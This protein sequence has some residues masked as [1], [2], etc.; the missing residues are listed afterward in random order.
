[1]VTLKA[2]PARLR[3]DQSSAPTNGLMLSVE[4]FK[5]R[6]MDTVPSRILFERSTTR[7]HG[8]RTWSLAVPVFSAAI[9]GCYVW[10]DRPVAFWLHAHEF[11]GR[12]LE[13][14]GFVAR[15]PNPLILAGVVAFLAMA[16]RATRKP[17]LAGWE[18]VTLT[19]A[20]SVLVGEVIKDVLKWAFGRPSPE[21]WSASN[22]SQIGE[23]EYQFH[24]FHGAEPFN[25]F[26]SGHMTAV[27]ALISVLWICYPQFRA[28]YVGTVALVATALVASNVHFVGDVIAGGLLGASIGFLMFNLFERSIFRR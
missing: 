14:V 21:T 11:G 10:I 17:H 2:A 28:I 26:P 20:L 15:T 7:G 4:R 18:Y 12:S 27:V 1:M 25:S 6:L 24:W 22:V 9:L 19:S 8:L 3:L 16:L 23:H 13:V 5:R